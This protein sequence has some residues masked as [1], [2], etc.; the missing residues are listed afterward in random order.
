MAGHTLPVSVTIRLMFMPTTLKRRI[1]VSDTGAT[2][3][4]PAGVPVQ[5]ETEWK[6][7][8]FKA[9]IK[10]FFTVKEGFTYNDASCARILHISAG[11][12][13]HHPAW[14]TTRKTA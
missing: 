10:T 13:L 4:I 2:N 8:D 11:R 1:A 5:K 14:H 7:A 6:A 9:P 12:Q 3:H